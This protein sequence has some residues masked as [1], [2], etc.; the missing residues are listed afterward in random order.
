MA[1]VTLCVSYPRSLS[2]YAMSGVEIAY[3]A[4]SLLCDVRQRK[5]L[6]ACYAM[7]GTEI[8]Y[9]ATRPPISHP[10]DPLCQLERRLGYA[11]TRAISAQLWARDWQ[12]ADWRRKMMVMVVMV[13]VVVVKIYEDDAGNDDDGDDDGDDRGGGGGGGDGDDD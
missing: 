13:I 7:S 10:F 3:D 8:A 9:G 2:S 6:P 5:M 1:A 4:T 11:S 12:H